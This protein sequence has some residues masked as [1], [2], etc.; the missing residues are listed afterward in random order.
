[1]RDVRQKWGKKEEDEGGSRWEFQTPHTGTTGSDTGRCIA[2]QPGSSGHSPRGQHSSNCCLDSI[3]SHS[4]HD[5]SIF[6][7]FSRRA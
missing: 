3:P 4:R 7:R 2:S 1:M 6:E 5:L